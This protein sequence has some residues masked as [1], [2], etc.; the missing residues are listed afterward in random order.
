MWAT[1]ETLK[2]RMQVQTMREVFTRMALAAGFRPRPEF[3]DD[4]VEAVWDAVGKRWV[5]MCECGGAEVVDPNEPVFFC[6][7]C[8]NAKVG[9]LWRPVNF[10]QER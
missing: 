3:A 8:G 6:C 5:A 9:G 1:P 4:E 2:K 7:S 10:P